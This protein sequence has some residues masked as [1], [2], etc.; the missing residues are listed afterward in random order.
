MASSEVFAEVATPNPEPVYPKEFSFKVAQEFVRSFDDPHNPD[1]QIHHAY[2]KV[3]DF[4]HGLLPDDVNPRSHEKL[5]GR[6]PDAIEASLKDQPKVFHLYNRGILVLAKH[7]RYDNR[8]KKLH[9]VISSP[10]DG[11]LVDGATTDRVIAN[12][13]NA[14]TL[15]DFANL[16]EDQIPENLRDAHVHVEIISGEIG[17]MLVPLAGAR[18]TS[19]QVKEFALENLG[20]GFDWLKDVIEASEFAGRVRYRENDPQPVDIRT[21]LGLLTMFHPKWTE[22]NKE[23]VIVYSAKGTV[24]DFYRDPEWKPGYLALRPVVLDIL[25]LYDFIHVEFQTQYIKYKADGGSGSKFGGRKEIRYNNGKPFTL[26]LSK[27][28][29]KYLIP[30]GWLYPILASFRMLLKFPADGAGEVQWVTDPQDFFSAHGQELVGDVVEQSEG[31]G[32]NPQ[33]TGKSR[34]LW[35]NLRKSMEL[36]RMKIEHAA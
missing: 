18:N 33:S 22:L 5:S 4:M 7:C 32:R 29:T 12:A 10:E 21:I 25:S 13:K 23:P 26:P 8:T 2:P 19:N 20:G 15:E 16:P 28:Q 6:V 30:D 34:P 24:L 9:I 14:I 11:G 17:D 1:L 3:R 35:N 31:L 27:A 36:S